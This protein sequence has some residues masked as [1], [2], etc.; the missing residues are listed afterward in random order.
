M[1]KAISD[2]FGEDAI[3]RFLKADG[4]YAYVDVTGTESLLLEGFDIPAMLLLTARELEENAG[5]ESP[6][7]IVQAVTHHGFARLLEAFASKNPKPHLPPTY[8]DATGTHPVPVLSP[9]MFSEPKRHISRSRTGTFP[10]KGA[11]YHPRK[12]YVAKL[13][14]D[15]LDVRMT[16]DVQREVI[17]H[18]ISAF[19]KDAVWFEGTLAL[20]EDGVWSTQPG[21]RI[22]HQPELVS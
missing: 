12:G 20:E 22:T 21:G 16:E 7:P 9:Q 13:T 1:T 3:S 14:A 11:Y 17:E 2:A 6:L 8:T 10:V 5:K 15:L 19:A 18:P 4:A